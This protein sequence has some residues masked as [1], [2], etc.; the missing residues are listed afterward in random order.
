MKKRGKTVKHAFVLI[1]A[2]VNLQRGN[3]LLFCFNTH[4]VEKTA[5]YTVG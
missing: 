4:T 2:T 1:V 5:L 3:D